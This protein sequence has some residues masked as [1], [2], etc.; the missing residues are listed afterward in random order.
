MLSWFGDVKPNEIPA[1]ACSGGMD[2]MVLLHFLLNA[3][4]RPGIIF[5]HHRTRSSNEAHKFLL[6]FS[7]ERDLSLTTAYLEGEKPTD[8]STEEW[9]RDERYKV[10]DHYTRLLGGLATAHHLDDAVETWMFNFLKCGKGYTIP[11]ARRGIVRPFLTTKREEIR[12][13]AEKHKVP[14]HTD[15]TNNDVKF[16]RNRIR[17][18]IMPEVLEVNPGIHK[19]VQR[20][21]RRKYTENKIGA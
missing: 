15:Q 1:I 10:L 20:L 13:W 21:I 5:F 12:Q 16:D 14:Y 3:G 9:W 18:R 4:H 8:K 19:V 17:H 11:Y 7:V 2:S 6:R